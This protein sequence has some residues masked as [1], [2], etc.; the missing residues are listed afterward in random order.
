[1]EVRVCKNHN[2]ATW[3]FVQTQEFIRSRKLFTSWLRIAGLFHAEMCELATEQLSGKPKE[4]NWIEES[5]L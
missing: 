5:L 4:M 1:M 3:H 2:N